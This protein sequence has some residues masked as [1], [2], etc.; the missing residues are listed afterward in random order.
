MINNCVALN[1][2]L[3]VDLVVCSWYK[4]GGMSAL[5]EAVSWKCFFIWRVSVYLFADVLPIT[6]PEAK[7][8]FSH[9]TDSRSSVTTAVFTLTPPTRHRYPPCASSAGSFPPPKWALLYRSLV[10]MMRRPPLPPFFLTSPDLNRQ[11]QSNSYLTYPRKST[12]G[13]RAAGWLPSPFAQQGV[14]S[15]RYHHHH[16]HNLSLLSERQTRRR[17]KK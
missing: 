2:C 11:H 6:R 4:D 17:N 10:Q 13:G 5:S 12:V 8:P 16:H 14:T 1:E 3:L 7:Q 15:N 9:K